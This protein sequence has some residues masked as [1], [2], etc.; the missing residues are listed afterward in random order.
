MIRMRKLTVTDENGIVGEFEYDREETTDSEALHYFL[1]QNYPSANY[2]VSFE[3][4]I[5]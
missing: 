5:D 2:S 1:C 3:N 4:V